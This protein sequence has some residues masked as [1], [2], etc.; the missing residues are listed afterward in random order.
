M[1]VIPGILASLRLFLG[2]ACLCGLLYPALLT[3]FC[4]AVWPWQAGGSLLVKEGQV[5]G[6]LLLGQPFSSARYFHSRPS[7]SN[8]DPGASGGSNWGPTSSQW[9][10]ALQQRIVTA[11]ATTANPVP[12]D[13][14]MASGSGL[15]PHISPEAARFQIPRVAHA[16]QLSEETLQ[17]LVKQVTAKPIMRL[18][19]A[20]RVN[21]LQLNLA[22]DA[23]ETSSGHSAPPP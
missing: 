10:A 4:Q 19:G 3:L 13:L 1:P 7:A 20:K 18:F 11:G 6:S 9:R 12:A 23:L 8:N 17:R 2:C 16:R 14:V 22:L 21:V 5:T 15:D